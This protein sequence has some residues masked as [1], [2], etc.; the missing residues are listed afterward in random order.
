MRTQYWKD[1]AAANPGAYSKADLQKMISR[2]KAPKGP[3]NR[4]LELH[5]KK[6]LASGG[7]N[8]LANLI[9]LTATQHRLEGNQN[10][11]HPGVRAMPKVMFT[12]AV[13]RCNA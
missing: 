10:I 6:P 9:E 11:N 13:V 8:D 4:P 12:P 5:H 3:D 7:L 2:V 1:K